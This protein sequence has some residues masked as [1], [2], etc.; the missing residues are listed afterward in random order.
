[1]SFV[2]QASASPWFFGPYGYVLQGAKPCAFV[3]CRGQVTVPF[4]V[5]DELVR[6]VMAA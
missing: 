5:D 6:E 1:M 2:V 4:D 3:P